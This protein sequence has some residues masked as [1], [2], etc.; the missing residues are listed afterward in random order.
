MPVFITEMVTKSEMWAGIAYSIVW[1]A[2]YLLGDNLIAKFNKILGVIVSPLL[3]FL[4]TLYLWYVRHEI[5]WIIV[6]L[7]PLAISVI[8]IIRSIRKQKVK[9]TVQALYDKGKLFMDRKDW[10]TAIQ[11]F[12]EALIIN[13]NDDIVYFY[14][15][16]AYLYK[17]DCDRA[18]AD[19]SET[20]R[21]D[22]NDAG[23]YNNRG[24]AYE[25]KGYI[26]QAVADY[27]C[28]LR[29]DPNNTQYRDNLQRVRGW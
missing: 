20:I 28:A 1:G 5:G 4:F 6:G 8:F 11:V 10:D 18:I 17:N 14:R 2:T 13:P 12:T 3:T 19:Y 7:I 23:A 15:G 25:R 29:L 24:Y 16:N 27:E 26:Q 21:I 22:P 9:N